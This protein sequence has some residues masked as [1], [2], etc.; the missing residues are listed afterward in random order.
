METKKEKRWKKERQEEE[1][2]RNLDNVLK[3]IR[4]EK[5]VKIKDS[6]IYFFI[7]NKKDQ[8]EES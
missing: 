8:K 3:I 7:L 5:F 4:Q 1:E 2:M 6:L